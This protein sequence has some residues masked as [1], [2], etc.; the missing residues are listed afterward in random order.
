MKNSLDPMSVKRADTFSTSYVLKRRYGPSRFVIVAASWITVL[1]LLLQ[2]LAALAGSFSSTQTGNYNANS[3]WV[4]GANPGGGAGN[5]TV[6]VN[7]THT[8]TITLASDASTDTVT[9][10][11]G[12][13]L[14]ANSTDYLLGG[15]VVLNGGMLYSATDWPGRNLNGTVQVLDSSTIYI[16]DLR[17]AQ[18]GTLT[19]GTLSFTGAGKTLQITSSV[20]GTWAA[21]TSLTMGANSGTI[22]VDSGRNVVLN[23]TPTGNSGTS[24]TKTGDGTL[25][26][27]GTTAWTGIGGVIV[28]AGTVNANAANSISGATVQVNAGGTLY[29]YRL[30][31]ALNGGTVVLNGGTLSTDVYWVSFSTTIGGAI[32]VSDNSTFTVTDAYGSG[33]NPSVWFDGLSFTGA[34]KTLQFNSNNGNAVTPS[35]TSLAVNAGGSTLQVNSP[36]NVTISGSITG[37]GTL[38]KDGAGTLTVSAASDAFT[39]AI[40]VNVGTFTQSG[41][42]T[43]GTVV[44]NGG[45][46][47]HGNVSVSAYVYNSGTFSTVNTLTV[48]KCIGG[49]GTIGAFTGL[50]GY[51]VGVYGGD[52]TG[53]WGTAGAGKLGTVTIT[54][55]YTLNNNGTFYVNVDRVS[56]NLTGNSAAFTTLNLPSGSNKVYLFAYI[57]AGVT[58]ANGEFVTFAT[59]S[60]AINNFNAANWNVVGLPATAAA[61]ST[62]N[63]TG[64]A[65][66]N[67][68]PSGNN[69]DLFT[70]GTSGVTN[71]SGQLQLTFNGSNGSTA[72][73]TTSDVVISTGSPSVTGPTS[74]TPIKSLTLGNGTT[75]PS[76]TLGTGGPL[77]VS[78]AVTVNTGANLTATSAA[79]TA[80]T[81]TLSGG[82]ATMGNASGNVTTGNVTAGTLTV[83]GGTVSTVNLSGTGS[84]AGSTAVPQVNVT[85]GTPAFSGNATVMTVTGGGITTTGGTIGTFNHNTGAGT[86]TIGA[87]TTITTAANIAAGIVNFNSTQT[88]NGTLTI[89]GGNIVIGTGAVVKQLDVSN[90]GSATLN[91]ANAL[92][93]QPASS[94]DT[95]IKLGGGGTG[96]YDSTGGTAYFQVSGSNAASAPTLALSGGNLKLSVPGGP[97][98]PIT[99]LGVSAL[100]AYSL[101]KVN[102]SY[103]G[104]AIQVRN[105]GGTLT[106]I[107]FTSSGELDTTALAAAAAGGKLTVQ[108]WYDQSGNGV[109][110]TQTTV[111]NQPVITSI[112]GT[113]YTN[114]GKPTLFFD[115]GTSRMSVTFSAGQDASALNLVTVGQRLASGAGAYTY[116]RW[117]SLDNGTNNDYENNNGALLFNHGGSSHKFTMGQAATFIYDPTASPTLN[118]TFV[119]DGWKNGTA[120]G[121]R[122]ND[123]E[124]TG[125]LPSANVNFSAGWIGNNRVAAD[126]GV[127]GY[128]SENI[129][130]TTALSGTQRTTLANN[131]QMYYGLK[132]STY[133]GV[134]NLPTATIA[135]TAA[136]T[137]DLGASGENHILGDLTLTGAT[138]TIKNANTVEFGNINASGTAALAYNTANGIKL[139]G[140][141]NTA[142]VT[143]ASG[144]TLTLDAA[145]T[146]VTA[147]T[148]LAKT[149]DGTLTLTGTHSYTAATQVNGGTLL[150]NGTLDTAANAVTVSG[151]GTLGGTGTINRPVNVTGGTLKPGTNGTGTLNVSALTMSSGNLAVSGTGGTVCGKIV[152]S[153]AV[154]LTGGTLMLSLSGVPTETEYVLVSGS[155]LNGTTFTSPAANSSFSWGGKT[156]K[157]TYTTTQV[158]LVLAPGGT[159]IMFK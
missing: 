36:A 144:G 146:T 132:T 89:T 147:S 85:G 137:L 64:G 113:I 52:P 34:N 80:A 24:L 139:R 48:N 28:N 116:P 62:V 112:S 136:S 10:N 78:G 117:W 96:K 142:T 32:Q 26:L 12:G 57:N 86:S 122:V 17:H 72:P 31:N 98:A 70:Y 41:N 157:L 1:N 131:Q 3:T 99:E 87:G 13:I 141:S 109:N 103:N 148:A 156:Y 44:V 115:S 63:W 133:A 120:G 82:N 20:T 124:T 42:L 74:A 54:P 68:W 97:P 16:N 126:S 104:Y 140:T 101:R 88:A 6:A 158:K 67:A 46:Y 111:A 19:L 58:P 71:P 81:L 9:V 11:A 138:L 155:T 37:S 159:V 143:V 152:S 114:G 149:G 4:E 66:D 90:P 2:P 21:F 18:D 102:S 55:A 83:N 100:R 45:T 153:G 14:T 154:S 95:A 29:S 151:T 145:T 105:S 60:T 8:V 38:T 92:K 135:A 119:L 40:R 47:T 49:T 123:T 150:V 118:Q 27:N 127:Y 23:S 128:I 108:T 107:G 50:S 94:S 7:N 134:V 15:T 75:T 129:L 5:D 22:N 56:G 84:L 39:G 65:G 106:D 35:F 91:A 121:I 43:S 125:T 69:W 93:I 53:S 130:F 25:H 110:A 73:V 79:L 51:G 61:G 77:T 33:Q 30:A 59:G 76:L